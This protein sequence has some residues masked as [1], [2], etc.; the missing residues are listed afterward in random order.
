VPAALVACSRGCLQ[1]A[2]A[3][4]GLEQGL[5]L[6]CWWLAQ[7]AACNVQL[8]LLLLSLRLLCWYYGL[9]AG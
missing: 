5:C 2:A 8:L 6:L 1:R 7:L 3:A 9:V 4:A